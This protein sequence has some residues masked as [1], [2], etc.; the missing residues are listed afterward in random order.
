[1]FTLILTLLSYANAITFAS[2]GDWGGHSLGKITAENQVKTANTMAQVCA[3]NRCEFIVNCGDNFYHYG[4]KSVVDPLWKTDYENI[5]YQP[6]LRIPWYN[7]LGNHDYGLNPEAQLHYRSIIGNNGI[8]RWNM[9]SRYYNWTFNGAINFIMLDTSPCINDYVNH[10]KIDPN[11]PEFYANVIAESCLPQSIWFEKTLKYYN[12]YDIPI[13]IIGH[14]PIYE[15]NN[16]SFVDII[17]GTGT[18]IMMGI[19]GHTHLLQHFILKKLAGINFYISG[20]GSRAPSSHD[21]DQDH[22]P[23]KTIIYTNKTN[24]F[25]LHKYI[26]GKITNYLYDYDGNMI[27][28]D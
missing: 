9:P 13:I 18:G 6:S 11:T 4:V 24:G 14:H 8:N 5:Y 27:Y 25:I 26:N 2:I 20:G 28:R 19:F 15:L 22:E 12:E 17:S 16:I 10:K 7:V 3:E 23:Y 1:M 21:P